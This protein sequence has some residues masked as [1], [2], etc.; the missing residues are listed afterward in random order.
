MRY[1]NALLLAEKTL[2]NAGTEIIP[3]NVKD[4]ISRITIMYQ[5]LMDGEGRM[6]SWAYSDISKIELVDGSDVLHSL[7]G[8]EN[9]A[10]CLYDRKCSTMKGEVWLPSCRG[11]SLYGIDFGRFLHD[12][13]LAFD[14]T[15]F[16]NPQLKITYDVNVMSTGVTY[17]YLSVWADCFDERV[18]TPSGFLMSKEIW[19]AVKPIDG[20]EEVDLPTDFPYR[21]MLLKIFKSA[22]EPYDLVDEVRLDEDNQKR[23]PFDFN[24][25]DYFHIMKGQWTPIADRLYA[26]GAGDGGRSLY[27]TPSGYYNIASGLIVGDGTMRSENVQRGGVFTPY[28]SEAQPFIQAIVEG[29]LPNHCVEFPFGDPQD[30]ADWYD[31]TK[32]GS[33]RLRLH[34]GDTDLTDC[35]VVLQQLRRY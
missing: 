7:D 2:T 12:P 1:R 10:L 27:V 24:L 25:E 5:A 22:Y 14:P 6:S 3:I 28:T 16:T 19:S 26:L 32:V 17:A 18:V 13:E 11:I 21:K 31:V 35:G 15:K 8:A 30:I 34:A 29:Y 9:M 33:L 4:I 23:V 20:Y